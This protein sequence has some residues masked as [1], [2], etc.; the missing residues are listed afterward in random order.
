MKHIAYRQNHLHSKGSENIDLSYLPNL[1]TCL[2]CQSGY[3][4]VLLCVHLYTPPIILYLMTIYLFMDVK[5]M[6]IM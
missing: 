1:R 5:I 3:L 4:H 2:L 6:W